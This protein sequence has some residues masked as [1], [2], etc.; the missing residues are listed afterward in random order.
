MVA[1]N[2]KKKFAPKVESGEKPSTI[3]QT[4]RCDVGDLIQ[5]YTGQRTKFCKK[6][7]DA[8]CIGTA[9][10]LVTEECPYESSN[11]EGIVKPDVS[12]PLYEQ[13]GFSNAKE[14][15]DFFREQ[16]GLP[17]VGWLHVWRLK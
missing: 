9:K 11:C 4:K 14:M 12:I 2:F 1:F 3:R 10:I 8:V 16:Y 17:F 13:E 15:Q 5:L 7:G 6:L